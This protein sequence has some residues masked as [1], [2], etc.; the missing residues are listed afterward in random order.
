MKQMRLS[1]L[2][3]GQRGTVTA[4][5]A[6]GAPRRRLRDLGLT[7]GC[8]VT[9]LGRSPFGDPTAYEIRG[10]VIAL[11]ESESSRVLIR[12]GGEP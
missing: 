5:L 12:R 3:P 2:S 11:R 6:Q 9:A 7:E 1:E 10:A 4:L 8:R